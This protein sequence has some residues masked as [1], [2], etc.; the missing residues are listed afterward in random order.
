MRETVVPSV[1][2]DTSGR[3]TASVNAGVWARGRFFK[4]YA[5]RQLSPAEIM[6]LV[7]YRDSLTGRILELGCGAG[8]LTGYLAAIG[9]DVQG[10]DLSSRMVEYCRQT[11]PQATFH[12]GDFTELSM[13]ADGSFDAIVAPARVLDV[14]DDGARGATLDDLHRLLS[15]DGLLIMSSNNRGYVPQL[16]TPAQVRWRNPLRLIN[17]T[18]SMP[19]R[20]IRRRRL[21]AL[22]R[23]EPGYAI[24]NDSTHG[25]LLVHY[26]IFRDDQER[27]F[28]EHGFTLLDCLDLEGGRVEVGGTAPGC[29]E[30]HYVARRTDVPSDDGSHS[31]S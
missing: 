20:L 10:I 1:S 13:F 6:L 14:L 19:Q 23:D 12:Q 5:T 16:R 15:E 31:D 4:H 21:L 30:L 26:F 29:V 17:D 9:R 11:L 22:E 28:S 7:R 25:Y 18:I 3:T 24:L 2:A 8:R 27:Q